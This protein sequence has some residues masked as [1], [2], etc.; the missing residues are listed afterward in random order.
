M[1]AGK[2]IDL[3]AGFLTQ[4]TSVETSAGAGDEGKLVSLNASGQ[5]DATMLDGT[6]TAAIATTTIAAGDLCYIT[7][8]GTIELAK[9]DAV[10]TLAQGYSIAGGVF[11]GSVTIRLSGE[12]TAVAGLT[13]GAVQYLSAATAG[14]ITATPPATPTNWVQPVGFAVTATDL[15]FHP[16][17]ATVVV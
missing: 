10:A 5:I 2:Y 6:Y 12:N 13:P 8:A 16:L 17:S 15:H 3:V 11:P 1:A 4:K 7:G 9:A 14:K